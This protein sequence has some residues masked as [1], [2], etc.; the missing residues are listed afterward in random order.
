MNDEVLVRVEGVSKK[1]CRS[2]RKSLWYGM[3]SLG[4]GRIGRLLNGDVH[5]ATGIRVKIPGQLQFLPGCRA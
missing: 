5:L 2:H 1:F 3:Q 4:N